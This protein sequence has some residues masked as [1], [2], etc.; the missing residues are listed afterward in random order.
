MRWRE[1]GCRQCE[2]RGKLESPPDTLRLSSQL[3]LPC[4]IVE[5]SSFHDAAI[6]LHD[7][8]ERISLG[9]RVFAYN[10][11]LSLELVIKAILAA[12]NKT[13]PAKHELRNLAKLADIPLDTD[14]L[15]TLDLLT[16]I[17]IW[18]GRYPAPKTEEKWDNFQDG[19]L[20]RHKVRSRSGNVGIVAID[21][22]R[23]PTKEN[24]IR[25]WEACTAKYN[26]K[27]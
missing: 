17:I 19:I 7:A 8:Q 14:Q 22:R 18:L 15:D 21:T 27:D 12:E 11:A 1:S 3:T 10:A 5:L 16:E 24:Y 23:F 13:I 4:G 20:E 25:I 2:T 9:F 26:H 6:V